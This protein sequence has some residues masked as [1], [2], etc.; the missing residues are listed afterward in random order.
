MTEW[1]VWPPEPTSGQHGPDVRD[2]LDPQQRAVLDDT[3]DRPDL[4]AGV[5]A[6]RASAARCWPRDYGPVSAPVTALDITVPGEHVPVPIRRYQPR[7][8]STDGVILFLHGGGWVLGDLDSHDPFCRAIAWAFRQAVVA[9]AYRLAPE[10]PFPAGLDDAW[11]VLQ[12]LAARDV[13][14][15]TQGAPITLFGDSAGGNIAA[16]LA[17][18]ARDAGVALAAQ[19]LLY[20]VVDVNSQRPSMRQMGFGFSLTAEE[21]AAFRD[22]YV[23]ER[24]LWHHPEVSPLYGDL[25]GLPP[26]TVLVAQ[27]DPLRD[28]GIEYARA[29][30]AAGVRTHLLVCQGAMHGFAGLAHRVDASRDL[31]RR[32]AAT[33]RHGLATSQE[34]GP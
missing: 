19:V 28:E 5:E 33:W 1:W 7:G 24:S 21:M 9:V 6:A 8:V 22:R 31:L 3:D 26:A 17:L 2:Q 27:L 29:L 18:R 32:L 12:A 20:P 23:P 30:A 16:A 13:T 14:G 10:H 25:R 34:S 11:A 15:V 4:A